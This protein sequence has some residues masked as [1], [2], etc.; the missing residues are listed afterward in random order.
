MQKEDDMRRIHA[1]MKDNFSECNF[2]I[3]D[4]MDRAIRLA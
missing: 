4:T 1:T 2:H 3:T